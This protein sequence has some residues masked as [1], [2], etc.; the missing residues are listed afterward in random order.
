MAHARR[1]TALA[2]A[3]LAAL[4]LAGCGGSNDETSGAD[5]GD[6]PAATTTTSSS[7]DGRDPTTTDPEPDAPTEPPITITSPKP[8]ASVH[9]TLRLTGTTLA[10]EGD[11]RWAILDASLEPMRSGSMTASC[12]AP[13]RGRFATTIPLASVPVGSWELHVWQPPVAD[14]DPE[15]VHDTMVPITITEFPVDDQPAVDAPPPGGAPGG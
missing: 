11:L 2:L 4:L 13:C 8:F 7:D 10:H 3:L 15:R 5:G 1:L 6:P 9:G 12:G 14:E